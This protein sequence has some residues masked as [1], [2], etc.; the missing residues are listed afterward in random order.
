MKKH[1]NHIDSLAAVDE[2]INGI[3]D[4]DSAEDGNIL[5]HNKVDLV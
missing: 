4:L 5:N 1:K 2:F 3:Q